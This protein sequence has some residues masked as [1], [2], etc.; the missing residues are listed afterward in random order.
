MQSNETIQ[1][2][3][4][5]EQYLP[6]LKDI[7]SI[8]NFSSK[9]KNHLL[10]YGC[11]IG[12]WAMIAS[13]QFNKVTGI[14]FHSE[15][16]RGRLL[17]KSN[18]IQNVQLKTIKN[19]T[20]DL[21]SMEIEPIDTLI[22]IMVIELIP[23]SQVIDLFEFASNNLKKGGRFLFVSRKRIGFLRTLLTLERFR[24]SGPIN[25]AKVYLGLAR[26]FLMTLLFKKIM[27]SH[28]PSFY[29]S[30]IQIRNLATQF[31]L[32]VK[33]SPAEMAKLDCV[34]SLE[35]NVSIK[36]FFKFRQTNWFVLEK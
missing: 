35:D 33:Y 24:Y 15:I 5:S 28:R 4:Y 25:A 31:D 22:S 11:G 20:S 6:W 14:D 16:H 12:V 9:Q 23:T 36:K 30:E 3:E 8:L 2:E 19:G 27:P 26:S 34:K 29:M 21:V 7:S 32:K 10:D 17:L 13:T 1:L 18:N